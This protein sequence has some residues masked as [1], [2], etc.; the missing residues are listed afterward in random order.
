MKKLLIVFLCLGPI[1]FFFFSYQQGKN[2]PFQLS[3]RITMDDDFYV[4]EGSRTNNW[5]YIT[6]EKDMNALERY[7]TLY[8]KNR[9][10]QNKHHPAF[11]I[12]KIVHIIWLGPKNFPIESVKHM[13]SWM[14]HHP[15]W[16]FY[17]WTDRD[18]PP[19]C[20]GMMRKMVQDFKFTQLE[21]YYHLS[22][23]WGEKSDILRYELLYEYGGVYSDHD[24]NCLK[25]FHNLHGAYDFYGC[26]EMPHEE[27][28][29][30]VITPGIGIIGSKPKHPILWGCMQAVKERWEEVERLFPTA[31]ALSRAKKV[32]HRTYIALTYAV[33][34]NLD[35]AGN[36]DIIFPASYFYAQKNLPSFYSKHYYAAEWNSLNDKTYE[37]FVQGK[38]SKLKKKNVLIK[39]MELASILLAM[40]CFGLLFTTRKHIK[41]SKKNEK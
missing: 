20:K 13:R 24:A 7:R 39:K 31:D 16:T 14:A 12:P 5:E 11:K 1:A 3:P 9:F 15:D 30:Y 38:L 34:N 19:P 4:L 32:M 36:T 23:N 41:R 37:K 35:L 27:I 25:P 22:D 28:N 2:A 33:E 8:E 17:Y 40:L 26:L 21:E 29:G 18:R 6:Q 10:L